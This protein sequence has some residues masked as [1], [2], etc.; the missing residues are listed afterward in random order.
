[1]RPTGTRWR[2]CCAGR[3]VPPDGI[4]PGFFI[5]ALAPAAKSIVG[6]SIRSRSKGALSLHR[7]HRREPQLL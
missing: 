6:A 1:M 4:V 2:R 5:D 7:A 3:A